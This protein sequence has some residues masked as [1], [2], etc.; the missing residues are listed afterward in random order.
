MGGLF[1]CLC[2]DPLGLG[3]LAKGSCMLGGSGQLPGGQ[4]AS[5]GWEESGL[6]WGAIIPKVLVRSVW[7][8]DTAEC[9]GVV[10]GREFLVW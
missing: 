7:C 10:W 5:V 1:Y 3:S 4:G 2:G 8:M 6:G 9:G